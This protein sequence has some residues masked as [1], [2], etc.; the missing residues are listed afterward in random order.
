MVNLVTRLM[1]PL[2]G[3]ECRRA[4][5]RGWL[6]LVRGLAA[7]VILGA[8]LVTLWMCWINEKIESTHQPYTELRV[9]L[10]AVEGMLVTVA[11]VLGPAVLAGSLAGEKERGTLALL[12]TTRVNALEIVT[13][14]LAG[15]LA[16]L[17]MVLLAGVPAVVLLAA[18]AGVGPAT[19]LVYLLLPAAVGIGGGGLAAVAS[20]VSRRGRDALLAVYLLDLFFMLS[21][22]ASTFGLPAAA[23]DW[24]AA[25]NPYS[26]LNALIFGDA[27][28]PAWLSIGVWLALGVLGTAVAAWRL[29]PA[30]LAPMD[31][32]RVRSRRGRRGFVPPVDEK[33]PMIWKELF[34]EHVATLGRFGKWAGVLLVVALIG[35]SLGLSAIVAWDV[36]RPSELA[37]DR[38]EVARRLIESW[39]GESGGFLC[40]LIQWAIGLRAAV[41]ISS[42]RERGTWDALLT[43]PLDAGEIVWGK[44][45]GSLYALRW[46]IVSAYVAWLAAAANDAVSIHTAVRWACEVLIVGGFMAAVGVRLS[47][48]CQTATRAMSLTIGA[49]LVAYVAVT[50]ASWL[51]LAV[52]FMLCNAAWIVASSAG[53][54]PAVTRLWIPVPW[55]IAYPVTTNGLYLLITL[56]IVADT[57]LRFDRIAGRMTQ[58]RVAIA[59]EE[60][61]YGRPTAPEFLDPEGDHQDLP[62]PEEPTSDQRREDAVAG[63]A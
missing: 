32:E 23:F 61:L 21:P 48:A 10:A 54:A 41:A 44:L 6:I 46:L 8:A 1:G 27:A 30:S 53:V 4:V 39:I 20:I 15:K 17:G 43:S 16:Q 42:E 12:L 57:R 49:W 60:F 36:Y 45:W 40:C 2:A 34:I 47:L 38:A 35:G 59:F 11:L 37:H 26:G 3:P 9:G 58:G 52:G 29:R 63:S 18:Q 13:G 19:I 50:V 14:R 22:L 31:G 33:R 28:G 62:P 5:A 51:I 24:V 56:L 55:A 7:V 25:L